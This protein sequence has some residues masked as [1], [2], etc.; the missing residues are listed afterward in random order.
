MRKFLNL[1]GCTLF[2]VALAGCAGTP[3]HELGQ[4]HGGTG[5]A[6]ASGSVRNDA[7]RTTGTQASSI[8]P[9]GQAVGQVKTDARIH[10]GYK[11][12]RPDMR[13]NAAK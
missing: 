10:P 1:C 9:G 5:I 12:P 7:S 2:I 4:G 3:A 6:S 11:S 13:R 8:Q